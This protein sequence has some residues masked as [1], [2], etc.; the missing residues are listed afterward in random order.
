MQHSSDKH[1]RDI[2]TRDAIITAAGALFLSRG[3]NN[4]SIQQIIDSVGIAKGT[5]YH[6][7]QSKEDL[8]D[9]YIDARLSFIVGEVETILARE[10]LNALQKIQLIY[11][12]A[13]TKKLEQK[14]TIK[15]I[16]NIFSSDSNILLKKKI[17]EK[18]HRLLIPIYTRLL[19]QG[20]DEKIFNC[21]YPEEIAEAILLFSDQVNEKIITILF[22][23]LSETEK[24]TR[25]KKQIDVF[26]FIL[27]RFL[28][29]QEGTLQLIDIDDYVKI[30]N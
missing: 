19:Q 30:L 29:Y 6:Y 15:I 1:P 12:S 27:Q 21:Q 28:G 17:T 5:F 24:Q 4:S 14:E 26:H 22:S 7:F 23:S 3:Y 20:N 18:N 2:S 10:D 13:R 8:L 11:Q 16:I 9:A 25:V